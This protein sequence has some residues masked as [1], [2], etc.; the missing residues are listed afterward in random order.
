MNKLKETL[1][2][3]LKG[4]G[5][6][7]ADVVPGVSGGTIAFITGIYEQLLDSIKAFD[8]EAF[9]LLLTFQV[10]PF[11]TKVNGRFL[12]PLFLGIITSFLTLAKL[13]I[14]LL[15]NHPIPLWSFFFG[16]III[17][18]ILVLRAINRWTI[19]V[20]LAILAGIAIAYFITVTSPAETPNE[21]WFVFI[22]GAIAVCAMILP[23]I[24][25]SFILLILGKYEYMMTA[26]STL[27]ILTVAIFALGCVV[28]LLSFV[29][30]ISWLLKN[31]HNLAIGLL[32]GFMIG[33][34]NKVWPW[35]IP[36]KFR[37]NSHGEQ[38]AYITRNVFPAEYYERLGEFPQVLVAI[39]FMA[40]GI[41]IV[42]AI[43]KIANYK[44]K[45]PR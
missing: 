6:G 7:G 43:E 10:I 17:S 42:V 9:K 29:R 5:M 39:L 15:A 13:I 8:L 30:V 16:L 2:T 24:S 28:G 40:L 19:G 36:I 25:G 44:S 26:L 11:W 35:K 21:P 1:L 41:F 31:Y 4:V 18:A 32:S 12:L 22:S 33:S 14:Y 34:L 38:V 23:G 3:Y 37:V 45:S 27:D 20:T